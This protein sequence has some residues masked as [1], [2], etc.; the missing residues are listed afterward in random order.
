MSKKVTELTKEEIARLFPVEITDY[1]EKW[2]TLF[3]EER[4]KIMETLGEQI[5][6]RVEHFGSTSIPDLPSKDI[7]DILLE[8]PEG[9]LPVDSI[10]EKMNALSYDFLWQPDGNPPYMHFVKGYNTEGVKEQ[11]Y[12]IHAGPRSHPLWNRIYFR[13]YLREHPETAKEYAALKYRLA[14]QYKHD[15]VAYRIAKTEFIME[16]TEKAKGLFS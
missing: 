10:V 3:N 14:E 16:V 1:Q 5:A 9:Q 4:V 2:V 6:L 8:V 12:H 7:I 15:R 13:D 11:M